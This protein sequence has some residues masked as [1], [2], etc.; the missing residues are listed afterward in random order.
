VKYYAGELHAF[1]A[2][3]WR[4][5]AKAFWRETYAFLDRHVPR[6]SEPRA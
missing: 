4:R 2:F 1:H 5:N 6:A 3:V